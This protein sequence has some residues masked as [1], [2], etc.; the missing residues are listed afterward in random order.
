MDVYYKW[1]EKGMRKGIRK[2][3]YTRKYIDVNLEI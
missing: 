3:Y 1:E 2:N